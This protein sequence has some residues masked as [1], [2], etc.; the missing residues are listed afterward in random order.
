MNVMVPTSEVAAGAQPLDQRPLDTGLV[1]FAICAAVHQ[2]PVDLEKLR[3]ELLASGTVSGFD[4]ILLAAKREGFKAR[5]IKTTTKRLS[6]TPLPAVARTTDDTFFVLA[7]VGPNSVLVQEPGHPPEEW[8]HEKLARVWTGELVLLTIRDTVAGVSGRFGF[9]WFLPVLARFKHILSEVIIISLFI[10]IIALVTPLIFQAVIDK[11]L[12]HKGFSTLDVLAIALIIT[13]TFDVLL[14]WL[15]TYVFAHTT[16]RVDAILGAKLFHHLLA[17][18]LSYFESRPAG[19]TV[20]RVRE[21]ENIRQFITSSA[22]TLLLDLSFGFIFFAVMWTIS[23]WLT[24]IVMLSIPVYVLISVVMTPLL[25]RKIDEKFQRGA[26]NQ[27]FLVEALSGVETLKAMALEP[28]MRMRWERQLAGYIKVSF[29]AVRLSAS[30]SQAVQWTNKIVTTLI[31]WFGAHAVISGEMTVGALVS[32]NMLSGQVNQPILRIA[33]MWQDFQQFRLS[34]ARLGDIIDTP[35]ETATTSARQDL[36]PIKGNVQFERV[37]FRYKPGGSEILK[38]VTIDIKAGQVIGVVGRSGSGKSTLAKLLQRLYVPE[39]GKVLVDGVD[40]AL[41]DPSWL[42]RQIGVV[43]QENVLFNRSVRE[44]IAL[45]DPAMPFEEVMAAAELAGA[46]EFIVEMAHGYDTILEERGSNLSGGQRQRI[47]IARALATKPSILVFDE[48]TSALDYESERKIQ[49]NM[50]HI[51]EGR[52][53]FL[54]AHRLSTVR[55][56]SRIIFMEKGNVVEDGPHDELIKK[57][58]P[59]AQL[60][61]AAG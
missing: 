42:R 18:P 14:G 8:D 1:A 55:N 54:I 49:E 52:T 6:R 32:F 37:I 59:Y 9:A 39:S 33:Q 15:R 47:A 7:K 48:A 60:V 38:G 53:V 17:L 36:P 29:E 22:L 5:R 57:G 16:S 25:K 24:T 21:L 27:S 26:A 3:R 40:V 13:G 58:G 2:K 11:V 34:L 10:Q 50:R 45:A 30:G 51:C 56:A 23:P 12:V 31:L 46:H 44:N 35:T 43:L 19:Q 20:A 61:A 28:Q 41:M 4:E